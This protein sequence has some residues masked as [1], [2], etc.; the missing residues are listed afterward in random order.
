MP[1][2]YHVAQEPGSLRAVAGQIEDLARQL[3]SIV[4]MMEAAGFAQ[5][6][7]RNYDQMRRG[8]KYLDNFIAAGRNALRE[9]REQRGDFRAASAPPEAKVSPAR[10]ERRRSAKKNR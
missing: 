3:Q 6:N 4:E 8:L 7:F 10:L 9:A 2:V 1:R 5:L